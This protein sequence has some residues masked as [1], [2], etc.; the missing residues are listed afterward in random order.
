MLPDPLIS[1]YEQVKKYNEVYY[2]ADQVAKRQYAKH[3]ATCAKNRAKR[4]RA[5]KPNKRK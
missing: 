4:K 2:R 1:L 3:K 5:K